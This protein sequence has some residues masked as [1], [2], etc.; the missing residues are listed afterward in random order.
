M[1]SLSPRHVLFRISQVIF[2]GGV[3]VE[4]TARVENDFCIDPADIRK[5]IT[6]RTKCIFIGY[7]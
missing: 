6:P 1:K 4:V 3:A 2:A 5:A 7:P